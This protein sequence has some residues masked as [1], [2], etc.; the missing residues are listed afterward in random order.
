MRIKR[1][2]YKYH[3]TVS[4][5]DWLKGDTQLMSDP[6]SLPTY[7]VDRK[8]RAVGYFFTETVQNLN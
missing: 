7:D 4:I 6:F 3:C 5:H 2:I 1:E 8:K